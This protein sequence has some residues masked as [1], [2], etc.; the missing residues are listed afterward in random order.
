MSSFFGHHNVD[1][2]SKSE[3]SD[4][5]SFCV[6]NRGSWQI[7]QRAAILTFCRTVQEEPD[8][9][10]LQEETGLKSLHK[11][12]QTSRRDVS[13]YVLFPARA[14]MVQTEETMRCPPH[15]TTAGFDPHSCIVVEA[16]K[17]KES[18]SE[19]EEC[20]ENNP[21]VEVLDVNI[22]EQH[23]LLDHDSSQEDGGLLKQE[24]VSGE[25]AVA[26]E[27]ECETTDV[28]PGLGHVSSGESPGSLEEQAF[29]EDGQMK[30]ECYSA[31]EQNH[32]CQQSVLLLENN[33]FDGCLL[34]LLNVSQ[35]ILEPIRR[36]D[37]NAVLYEGHEKKS[38]SFDMQCVSTV[39]HNLALELQ[40]ISLEETEVFESEDRRASLGEGHLY[41]EKQ[42]VSL[43]EE[44]EE[45]ASLERHENQLE[46]ICSVEEG[47]ASVQANLPCQME[48]SVSTENQESTVGKII[49]VSAVDGQRDSF[50]ENKVFSEKCS[51]S[52]DHVHFEIRKV[53]Q[54]KSLK[55]QGLFM[56]DHKCSTKEHGGILQN[57]VSF[58]FQQV[59]VEDQEAEVHNLETFFF[60]E[61]NEKHNLSV[62]IEEENF[63]VKDQ[64]ASL[65]GPRDKENIPLEESMIFADDKMTNAD[66]QSEVN[67]MRLSK[68]FPE[69]PLEG[70]QV[71]ELGNGGV[72]EE[73]HHILKDQQLSLDEHLWKESH[74]VLTPVTVDTVAARAQSKAD[75][76]DS[77]ESTMTSV[78]PQLTGEPKSVCS[79]SKH[80]HPPVECT[81]TRTTFTRG[82]PS[83]G[84]AQLPPILSGLRVLRKGAAGPE[85]DTVAAIRPPPS[86][87]PEQQEKAE[88]S[89]LEQISQLLNWE[90]NEDAKDMFGEGSE[91]NAEALDE[92]SHP[93]EPG[94]NTSVEGRKPHLSSAEAAFDAFKA[95]FTPK[96]LKKEPS[97][98]LEAVMRRIKADRDVLKALFERKPSKTVDED[99][100]GDKVES[101]SPV[102]EHQAAL[103]HLKRECQDE[104]E[105][106]QGDFGEQLS[107]LKAEHLEN[108]S[109]LQLTLAELR[110]E[111]ARASALGRGERRD[112]AVWTGDQFLRKTF[113]TLCIQTDGETFVK[114]PPDG[115]GP[116][117]QKINPGQQQQEPPPHLA[118][119]APPVDPP[120]PA[121]HTTPEE[122]L[123]LPP[124]PPPSQPGVTPP[125]P[126]PMILGMTLLDKKP[127]KPAVDPSR[128]MKPL[129]WTRIQIEDNNSGTLWNTLEEPDILNTVEFENLFAKT[130]TENKKKPLAE[131]YE[132][133][134][135]ALKIKLL[136][137]KRSQAVGIL[138]SSL[139]LEMKDI[140]QAILS[141]DHSVVDLETVEALYE[142]RAQ[143]DELQRIKRHYQTS[144]EDHVKLLDKPEQFLYELAEIPDFAGRARCIIFRSAFIDGIAAIQRKLHTVSSVCQALSE[145]SSVRELMGLVLAFGNHMNG[146]SRVRGQADGF[147]LEILPKLKDVK[148]QD[149]RINL[150]DYV[151]SYYLHNMDKNA[152]TDKSLF[153]LP[154]PQ[155]V[156]MA[157]QVKFEDLDRDLRQLGRDLSGSEN[158]VQ[159]VCANSPEKHLQPFQDKMEAFLLS[160]R[161]DQVEASGQL[162]SAQKSFQELVHY[163]GLAPKAGEKEVTPAHFF[164]LWFEFCADFKVRWKRENKSVSKQRLKEAQ[165]SVRR[166]TQSD[167][168]VETRKVNPNSLKQR[169]RQKQ[170]SVS[171]S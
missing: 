134:P 130:A 54:E 143:P 164:M 14:E 18:L 125:P 3:P 79:T 112:A 51:P 2:P 30:D 127:R 142:N 123:N 117:L 136:D 68:R 149:N 88:G 158:A 26:R 44:K 106:L 66:D 80:R 63:S 42:S 69:N 10:K 37:R 65:E 28:S 87:P 115:V 6:N 56:E 34:N 144:P 16:E 73:H 155:D 43:E 135:K 104:L 151:V 41:F 75:E 58:E 170:A 101:W 167:K 38:G 59:L 92:Q 108:I 81:V 120:A 109:R 20:D 168:R 31:E 140:Q 152:G 12:S 78:S 105:K 103:L 110:T 72:S 17:G 62:K 74:N 156:F 122:T 27:E 46:Q 61:Q 84:S 53:S 161:K 97:E 57:D 157:A 52:V 32:A 139:H 131:T 98:R 129:Y 100:P 29:M 19:D 11:N 153:P 126:P 24:K 33:D 96:P 13:S 145:R 114:T 4:S 128:P 71:W 94:D 165:M 22:G 147:G 121:T 162:K 132:K 146:G 111:L 9:D 159:R 50:D 102:E 93:S 35:E 39:E 91:G 119:S 148:S 90:K 124:P 166:I 86:A 23:S 15:D 99:T 49:D 70:E 60:E 160:A 138:I 40:D 77:V 55:V 141:M 163:F 47:N 95:F 113:R 107:R 5:S 137:G 116:V 154:E 89:F 82:P 36:G 67:P 83:D 85:H 45:N 169:L 76:E 7:E 133:K 25:K 8:E 48:K 118:A 1:L 21:L 64:R 171:S 150:V